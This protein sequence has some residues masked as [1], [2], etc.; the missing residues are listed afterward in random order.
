M[1]ALIFKL[2]PVVVEPTLIFAVCSPTVSLPVPFVPK[3]NDAASV[4]RSLIPLCPSL[5]FVMSILFTIALFT[6]SVLLPS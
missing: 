6:S 2:S 3:D 1:F 5:K 4:F